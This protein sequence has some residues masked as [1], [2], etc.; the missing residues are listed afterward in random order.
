[1]Y[2]AD[3]AQQKSGEVQ[4]LP[5]IQQAMIDQRLC[6]YFQ[7]IQSISSN[8]DKE[9]HG[10]I[11]LR[12]E[13]EHGRLVTPGAFLPAAE[14]HDHMLVIDRWVLEHSFK[15]IKAHAHHQSNVIYTI[16]LSAQV[17]EST[18]FLDF[19]VN[20]IK[21]SKL[22]PACI[23]FEI[24]E[25]VALTETNHAVRFMTTLKELGCRFSMDN[26]SGGLSSL[27]YLKNIPLDYLK[28]DGRLIKNMISDP[29]DQAMVESI[30]H[31]GHVM[32]LKT[33][34]EW[35]ENDQTLQ[36]LENMGIDY[37]QGY[38]IA[39]PYPIDAKSLKFPANDKINHKLDR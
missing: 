4:W 2:Q 11:L 12:L 7:P 22:N 16:N 27:G 8:N 18:D 3:T 19:A 21:A 28:I 36:L 20:T 32:R 6:L 38:W 17:L 33:I 1:V 37:A 23:C 35:V 25:H 15:L 39:E 34:A 24:T 10:E 26:F 30:N 14:R 9:K 5:R 29:V 31:I 13:D